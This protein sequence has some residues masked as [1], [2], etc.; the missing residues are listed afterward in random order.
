MRKNKW[1]AYVGL[2]FFSLA[3][4]VRLEFAVAFKTIC[5]ATA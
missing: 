5:F 3:L 4:D 1:R 2:G